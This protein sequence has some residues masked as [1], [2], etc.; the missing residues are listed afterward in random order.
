MHM[1][2]TII[3]TSPTAQLQFVVPIDAFQLSSE[4]DAAAL[5]I[6]EHWLLEGAGD[7][8]DAEALFKAAREL[9]GSLGATVSRKAL[10]IKLS[11][12]APWH[13]RA[14]ALLEQVVLHPRL[15][16]TSIAQQ[17]REVIVE[18]EHDDPIT[19][20]FNRAYRDHFADQYALTGGGTLSA[21]RK[22][23]NSH[24]KKMSERYLAAAGELFWAGP[25]GHKPPINTRLNHLPPDYMFEPAKTIY[26]STSNYVDRDM[27]TG[28]LVLDFVGDLLDGWA[29]GR[30]LAIQFG[31]YV[32]FYQHIFPGM[33]LRAV[34]Y[35]SPDIN[36][37]DIYAAVLGF[38]RLDAGQKQPLYELAQA[39][40]DDNRSYAE[41]ANQLAIDRW[42]YSATD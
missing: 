6:L 33:T 31:N 41:G 20:L 12:Y 34:S 18:V 1:K 5:H 25:A 37:R 27:G 38:Q 11:Y 36:D 29:L 4:A 22:L 14:L 28:L 15:D 40:L 3:S 32:A 10:V 24:I 39:Y 42:I 8:A 30:H 2:T 21:L 13:E 9:G 19:Q 17:K 35:D 26:Q 23:T 16:A 7:Y